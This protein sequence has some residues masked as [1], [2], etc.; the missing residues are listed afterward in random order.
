[1]TATAGNDTVRLLTQLKEYGILT[2]KLTLAGAAG[3][4]TQENIGAMGGAGEGFLSAAG[5]STDIDTAANKKFVAAFKKEFQ[6]DPDLFGADTYGLFFLFKQAIE[7]AGST[8]PDKLRAAM[9]D[10]SWETPQGTKTIRKG[11]HQAVVDMVV[12]KVKGNDFHDRRQGVRRGSRWP[13]QVRQ[14]LIHR[15]KIL[16]AYL[17][18]VVLPQFIDALIIGVALALVAL[19][20]T[21]IFGL[22]D[23][24]NL[25][26]GELYMLGGYAAFTLLGWGAGYWS[27]LVLVPILVGIVGWGL[28]ELGFA[29][30]CRGRIAPS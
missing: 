14:V 9:E 3:A 8:D 4:V 10:A 21:M 15:W 29:R 7:K 18:F 16:V 25:A 13:R 22:L 11:D 30:C 24:I 20:L 17:H 1:M 6:N 26:H 28:E 2:D 5:Y 12:V 19:G 27:A 23:V